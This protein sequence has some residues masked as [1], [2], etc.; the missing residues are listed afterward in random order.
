MQCACFKAHTVKHEPLALDLLEQTT[1]LGLQ[2][3]FRRLGGCES[4]NNRLKIKTA[5][6]GCFQQPWETR[7]SSDIVVPISFFTSDNTE[8]RPLTAAVSNQQ[9]EID[10]KC[11]TEAAM[12]ICSSILIPV[13]LS[14]KCFRNFSL[15]ISRPAVVKNVRCT[16]LT[17]LVDDP[18]LRIVL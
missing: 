1:K 13:F 3:R 15:E 12:C 6:I 17:S 18:A 10:A 11:N 8:K 2:F 4:V 5:D 9:T 7:R 16:G 14:R